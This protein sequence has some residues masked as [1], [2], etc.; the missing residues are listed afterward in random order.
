MRLFLRG[1]AGIVVAGMQLRLALAA[2]DQA[3]GL[4][5]HDHHQNAAIDKEPVVREVDVQVHGR[6]ELS[7]QERMSIER[8]YVENYSLRKDIKIL[9]QTLATVISGRGLRMRA[10]SSRLPPQRCRVRLI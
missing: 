4:E 10:S 5:E 3:L 9:C 2:R 7:F 6:G 8:E 1:N